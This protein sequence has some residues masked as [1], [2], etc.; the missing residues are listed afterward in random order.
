[1][2]TELFQEVSVKLSDEDSLR[3]LPMREIDIVKV[4]V[5]W[6]NTP[7]MN[8][9]SWK[10]KNIIS[11]L[12]KGDDLPN[13]MNF[14][15]KRILDL[16]I[17]FGKPLEDFKV[18]IQTM[19]PEHLELSEEDFDALYRLVHTGYICLKKISPDSRPDVDEQCC[20]S[21]YHWMCKYVITRSC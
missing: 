6:V 4:L 12:A 2:R 7:E 5:E 1:M 21:S 14:D 15:C 17:A 10:T 18:D 19:F 11:K 20:N 8:Q 16:P 9:R 3:L 13:E